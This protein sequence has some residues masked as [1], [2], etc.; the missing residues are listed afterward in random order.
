MG[1]WPAFLD[2]NSQPFL[3]VGVKIASKALAIRLANVLP[4]II[5]VGQYAYVKD[6]TIFD[7][8]RTID[9]IMEYTKIKQIYLFIYYNLIADLHNNKQK[10]RTK[11]K[12]KNK[13]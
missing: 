13:P 6:R 9:D 5:Q 2:P 11:E 8:I 7:A 10:N 4:Q 1:R 12:Q 3:N